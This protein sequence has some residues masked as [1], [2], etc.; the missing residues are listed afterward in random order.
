MN[1]KTIRRVWLLITALILTAGV[2][3][4][5]LADAGGG[6]IS[7]DGEV[8]AFDAQLLAEAH[9]GRRALT[10]DQQAA[11]ESWTAEKILDVVLGRQIEEGDDLAELAAA[12]QRYRNMS[13]AE[14]QA[15]IQEFDSIPAFVDW[16]NAAKD[17]YETLNPDIEI[18]EDGNVDLGGN[19]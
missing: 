10:A 6:D 12:Y 4:T 19:T 11:A 14:Q 5:A 17:A 2:A 18:G 7:G 1:R 8:T 3:L 9:S 16:L 15:F 13:G